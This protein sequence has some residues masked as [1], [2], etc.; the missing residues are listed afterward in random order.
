[1][2]TREPA[3]QRCDR[4]C[5]P[6]DA[7][8]ALLASWAQARPDLDMSPVAVVSR[9][10]R[11]RAHLDRELE[12]V[13][14]GFDL[15]APSFAVL[16]TLA[17]IA[18]AGGVS[19]RRLADELGLTPGTVSVRIDRL[20]DQGLVV[21]TADPDSKRSLQIALTATG[22]ARFEQ[23]VPVHLANE[24]R[25]LAA[26]DDTERPLL[27]DLLRK[28]LVEFEGS[29][30]A[31]GAG[32]RLG[33]VL[34]PAHVTMRLRQAVGLR[35][36]AGLLVRSVDPDSPAAIAGIAPGDVLASAGKRPLRSSAA[37]YAAIEDHQ[38]RRLRLTVLRGADELVVDIDLGTSPIS[39]SEAG[40]A[41]PTTSPQHAL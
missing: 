34:A 39:G 36:V 35:A 21:R 7:I 41:T 19:Q 20:V 32:H 30:P 13:F 24:A 23:V 16:V 28:L 8:D 26:L 9:L 4:E 27:A 5:S 29:R 33:L 10:L 12:A 18:G 38:G 1:V 17:R 3:Q 22:H 15:T 11:V 25:L 2:A 6:R 40:P 14:D 31:S 37:L